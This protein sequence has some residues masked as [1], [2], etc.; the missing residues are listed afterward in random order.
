[1][2]DASEFESLQRGVRAACQEAGRAIVEVYRSG[3]FSVTGKADRSPV[4]TADL[5]A[6]RILQTRLAVLGG[7]WPI[8]SE[9]SSA[10]ELAG[11]RGW[12]RFWLVDPL[13]GTKEFLARTGEFSINVALVEDGDVRLGVVHVPITGVAYWGA[14]GVGAWCAEAD[15][16]ARPIRTVP[17]LPGRAIRVVGSRSH[18]DQRLTSLLE[19]LGEHEF[20]AIGSA[21]KPCLIAAGSAD[22]YVRYG[23]T[24]EW[25]TAAAQGVLEG[26]GGALTDLRGEPLRCNQRDSL[27]NPPFMAFGDPG[28]GWPQRLAT[29][30]APNR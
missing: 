5:A 1:M 30:G 8:L 26:A 17:V 4:T 28:F 6:H 29:A 3:E 19:E 27:E 14:R 18:A 24:S 15:G 2:L 9:E 21:L 16:T 7:G 11:R 12:R 23:P 13:D 10:A 22:L 25:D 20:R